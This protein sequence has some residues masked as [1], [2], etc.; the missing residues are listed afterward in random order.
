MGKTTGAARA[1]AE[2]TDDITDAIRDAANEI[3]L[4]LLRVNDIAAALQMRLGQAG[5][6]AEIMCRDFVLLEET[7][8]AIKGVE[9]H[10]ALKSAAGALE[11]AI[12]ERFAEAG[13]DRVSVGGRTV[14]P[15]RQHWAGA[16]H[17]I[18]IEAVGFAFASGEFSEAAMKEITDAV[19]AG[20]AKA[21]LIGA[22]RAD[23]QLSKLLYETFNTNTLSAW[24]RKDLEKDEL[25]TPIVPE[26]L[27]PFLRVTEKVTLE[28][29]KSS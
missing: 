6:S 20:D 13:V 14:Y 25:G 7:L 24:A 22:M 12:L 3:K 27:A 9:K 21:A 18:D 1:A 15:R 11:E 2:R 4:A 8:S 28:S 17:E 19:V 29:R 5:A 26:P 10:D 16:A 23:P